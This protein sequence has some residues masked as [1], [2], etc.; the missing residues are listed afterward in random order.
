MI[1]SNKWYQIEKQYDKLK[2][3]ITS[4]I[5]DLLATFGSPIMKRTDDEEKYKWPFCK[6]IFP[7]L[8][9]IDLFIRAYWTHEDFPIATSIVINGKEITPSI[10]DD[11]A[12]HEFFKDE[13]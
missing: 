2:I 11:S 3:E 8:K 6:Y 7:D 10:V 12:W 9:T 1:I 4:F 5:L 13:P